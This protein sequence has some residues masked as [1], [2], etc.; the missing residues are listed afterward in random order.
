MCWKTNLETK[1]IIKIANK[2]HIKQRSKTPRIGNTVA[3]TT[4]V[5]DTPSPDG[6]KGHWFLE[7]NKTVNNFHSFR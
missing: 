5:V 7:K 3:N 6:A 2:Q 1:R 4:V